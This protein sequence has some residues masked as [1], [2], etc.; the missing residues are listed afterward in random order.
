MSC[1]EGR[2]AWRVY[3]S[4]IK[5]RR[6]LAAAKDRVQELFGELIVVARF[7]DRC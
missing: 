5:E 4:T 2:R 6:A 3:R 1:T 7:R